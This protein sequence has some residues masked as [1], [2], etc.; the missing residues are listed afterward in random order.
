[1]AKIE[2]TER[3]IEDLEKLNTLVVRRILRKV[4]WFAN[5][6]ERVTLEPLAGDLKGTFKLRVGDW[7]VVFTVEDGTVVI[8]FVGHRREVYKIK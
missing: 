1:L 6:F 7:R 5:N 2:W 3:A 8:Q 4:T